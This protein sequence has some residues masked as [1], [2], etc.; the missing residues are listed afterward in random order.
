MG[1]AERPPGRWRRATSTVTFLSDFGLA[2]EF[3]GEVHLVIAAVAPQARVIDLTHQVPAHDVAAAARILV[4]ASPWLSEVVLALVDP[5]AGSKRRAVAVEVVDP[6]GTPAVVLVGPDNGLLPPAVHAI[7]AFGRAVEID[8]GSRRGPEPP[9]GDTFDGRDVLAVAAADLCNGVDLGALGPDIDPAALMAASAVQPIVGSDGALAGRVQWI[10]RF[11]NVEL[12]IAGSLV[13]GWGQRV[14]VAAAGGPEV[15][16][17]V[18]AAYQDIPAGA[19]GVLV[20]SEGWVS[21][22][23]NRSSAAAALGVAEGDPV[24]LRAGR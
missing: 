20:D 23:A 17:T 10:D 4:R 14:E 22:A 24:V 16:V 11:G 1:P 2:D 9:G 5:G 3:V 12:D 7:G 19:V 6:K 18:V 21:L 13:A 8:R 15:A